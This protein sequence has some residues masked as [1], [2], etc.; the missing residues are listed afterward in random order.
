MM[1]NMLNY[2]KVKITNA[3]YKNFK[4]ELNIFILT[5][6]KFAKINKNKKGSLLFNLLK[7]KILL[8]IIIN[9]HL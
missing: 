5:L 6:I 3:I 8:V 1:E 9:K 2:A 7:N 4:Q